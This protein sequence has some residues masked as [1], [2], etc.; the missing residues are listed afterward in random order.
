MGLK[1]EQSPQAHDRDFAGRGSG[2]LSA[3]FLANVLFSYAQG[4]PFYCPPPPPSTQRTKENN[5]LLF[6]S[7]SRYPVG[8]WR[9]HTCMSVHL[10]THTHINV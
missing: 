9:R 5:C 1:V 6:L 4:K 2:L 8:L 3:H 10:Y 7:L